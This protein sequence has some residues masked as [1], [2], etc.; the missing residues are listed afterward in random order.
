M[1]IA[2]LVLLT[3]ASVAFHDILFVDDDRVLLGPDVYNQYLPLRT[4]GFN[5]L[6]QGNLPLWNPHTY[7][8][9]AG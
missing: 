2:A 7:S 4:F 1:L 9:L 6:R 5:E 8:G 3:L